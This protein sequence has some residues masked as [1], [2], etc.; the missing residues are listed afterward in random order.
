MLDSL[1]RDLRLALRALRAHPGFTLI[2]I[3][4][5]ALGI[6]A[7]TAIFSVVHRVLLVP[8][9]F[10]EPD[11]VVRVWQNDRLTGTLREASSVPDFYDFEERARS[12]AAVAAFS[13]SEMNLIREDAEPTRV[14]AVRVT[15]DLMSL[16][17]VSPRLG[18][19]IQASEDQPGG[20]RV[21]LL[22]DDFWSRSF[23]GDPRAL[24][25]LLILDEEPY[26]I[27]GVLPAG[28]D[29]PD[30][31][32]DVWLPLQQGR[33]SMPRSRHWVDV[34]ARLAPGVTVAAAQEEMSQ[35][36]ADL[37]REYSENRAR[38][39]FVEPLTEVLRGEVRPALSV[40]FAA[41]L[42]LLLIA[43]ANV[44]SLL[45]ARGAARAR[46]L[47]VRIALGSGVR[48]LIRQHL[49]ESLLL[50]VIAAAAGVG[51]AIVGLRGL[52]ALA[53][54]AVA[55]AVDGG[56]LAVLD[57]GVLAF[58]VSLCLAVG[59]GFSLVPTLQALRLD[60]QT[61]LRER[62][63][64][65]GARMTARRALVVAQMA[66]ASMLLI[67]AGLL[68][69]SLHEL[70]AVDPGF[71]AA[72][73]LRLDFELPRSRYPRDFGVWPRWTEVHT[74]NRRL[75]ERVEA[76][77]G[78]DAA[79]ITSN[80]PLDPGFTTSFVIVGREDEAAEQGEL[81]ARMVSA[82]Y[83]HT[84]GLALAAGRRFDRRDDVETAPVLILNQAAVERYFP[85][86]HALD[87]HIRFWGSER[88]VVG[89][90]ADEKIHGLGADTP[91]AMYVPLTQAP[92]VGG[93]TL[94]VRGHADPR[95][96]IAPLRDAVWALDPDLAVFDVATM[97]DTVSRSLARERFTSWLLGL[98]AA[99]AVLLAAI[100]VHGAL[101]FL[102]T[103]RR[104][105]IGI[106]MAMGASRGKI[107]GLVLSQGMG[108]AAGGLVIGLA[109]AGA[110][111]R[112]LAGLLYGVSAF[113]LTTYGLVA[114]ALTAAILIASALPAR[115][116]T[117][118]DPA[119]ALR[120]D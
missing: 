54:A 81:K 60:V 77:P 10:A 84:T 55:D 103:R 13:R 43:C 45:L 15:H 49:V 5:L 75:L 59:V 33:D 110:A 106:R 98:F 83:F 35:I 56:A 44:A 102:I 97:D 82:G 7:S 94:M 26:E 41:V 65:G 6:G 119:V 107:L 112:W 21:A 109:G 37:E 91:P 40:L 64:S 92:Q 1:A 120:A 105:E 42:C 39:A 18:R 85:D 27:A 67:S 14:A 93:V 23:A 69:R 28:L 78:V 114:G 25:R 9:P 50:T 96:L 115:Q 63:S 36:A 87:E 116:A 80:H 19:A 70:R 16:L 62:S 68:I 95:H 4:T 22:S 111:S 108:L 30:R 58:T 52:L 48:H 104:R 100:G 3:F 57:G 71:R 90:V 12:F 89:I 86:G 61:S 53:P 117:G 38:G 11:R 47:A 29:F 76:L 74:F 66:L 24:G 8:L 51:L 46:D 17:G 20:A 118:V 113:D 32:T 72:N 99:V 2:V 88:R 79:A 34:V 101:S 73:V 31:D